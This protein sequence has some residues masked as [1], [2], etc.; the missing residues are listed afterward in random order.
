[1]CDPLSYRKIYIKKEKPIPNASKYNRLMAEGLAK[2]GCNVTALDII[3]SKK[4]YIDCVLKKPKKEFYRG[5]RHVYAP[6]SN[7]RPIRYFLIIIYV[8][9]KVLFAKKDTVVIIDGLVILASLAACAASRIRKFK[10]ICL[11]TDLPRYVRT[12]N[13]ENKLNLK[14]FKRADSFVFLTKQMND[15]VNLNNKP[16]IVLEGHSDIMTPQ[17]ADKKSLQTNKIV[18]YAGSISSKYGIDLLCK[19]FAGIVGDAELHIYGAGDFA[20]ELREYCQKYQNIKYFGVVDNEDVV[21]AELNATLLVNPRT[22]A[23]EYTYYSFPSKTLEYMATGTPVLMFKLPGVPNEYDEHLFYFESDTI[24]EM[25]E[26]LLSC[27]NMD[28]SVLNEKG[29]RAKDFVIKEK[30]N[31]LQSKKVIDLINRLKQ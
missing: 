13:Y 5:V 19:A 20:N 22:S 23:G 12:T 29:R 11:V 31:V 21:T 14:I 17:F 2:N 28:Q 10:K 4:Q 9:L 3:S 18:L 15:V 7:I 30:N 26:T 24:D 6:I 8:F 1:M 27:L 25:R 16:F